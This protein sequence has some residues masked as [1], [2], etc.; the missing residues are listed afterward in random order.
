[1]GYLI[2]EEIRKRTECEHQFSCL[3]GKPR[4]LCPAIVIHGDELVL[5]TCGQ[6]NP[7]CKYCMPIAD[8]AGNCACPTRVE[9]FKSYVI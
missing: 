7:T 4:P 3:F 6:H 8:T 1:M 2:N 9:L 5:T